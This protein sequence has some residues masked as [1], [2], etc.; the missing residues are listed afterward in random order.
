MD[1]RRWNRSQA[2]YAAE[3]EAQAEVDKDFTH[4]GTKADG[5]SNVWR[6]RGGGRKLMRLKLGKDIALLEPSERG[7]RLPR[8]VRS[9]SDSSGFKIFD[10][11]EK[12]T[13]ALS[14]S[15][16]TGVVGV[17][18]VTNNPVGDLY[19]SV[20]ASAVL[21]DVELEEIRQQQKKQEQEQ[22]VPEKAQQYMQGRRGPHR[23]VAN[24]C[25]R[26]LA[27]VHRATAPSSP[28]SAPTTT[29]SE[30]ATPGFS[31]LP[32]WDPD[33]RPFQMPTTKLSPFA[34]S[35]LPEPV[36][37][38]FGGTS[39][40]SHTSQPSKS[41]ATATTNNVGEDGSSSSTTANNTDPSPPPGAATTTPTK[42][43]A[44]CQW[45]P[46]KRGDRVAVM[47]GT[48]KDF[49]LFPSFQRLLFR[50]LSRE[51]FED[52][53]ARV[54]R[55]PCP[56][57]AIVV[58]NTSG[59]GAVR[60]VQQQMREQG[61]RMQ[62]ELFQRQQSQQEEEQGEGSGRDIAALE[63]GEGSAAN[64]TTTGR[65]RAWMSW[66]SPRRRQDGTR[67][68]SNSTPVNITTRT[69]DTTAIGP[70]LGVRLPLP[71]SSES[72]TAFVDGS[73]SSSS[74][75]SSANS[76]CGRSSGEEEMKRGHVDDEKYGR[77]VEETDRIP[78]NNNQRVDI[79]D[80]KAV[81]AAALDS[82]ITTTNNNLLSSTK[83]AQGTRTN[84]ESPEEKAQRWQI[85]EE[86]F[87][88]EDY[89]S[90]EYSYA[91]SSDE[92]EDEL[93]LDYD[94]P[95]Y[96]SEE[97]GSSDDD[98]G[99]SD[100]DNGARGRR[101]GGNEAATER[102]RWG[103]LDWIHFI[104]FCTPHPRTL[105]TSDSLGTGRS[106]STGTGGGGV[107]ESRR[108]RR[109]RLRR[110]RW[111]RI[112]QR[113][114]EQE[115]ESL[116]RYLP[117]TIRRRMTAQDVHR[118]CMVAEFCRFYLTILMALFLMGAIVYGAVHAESSPPPS[119]KPSQAQ[120]QGQVKDVVT[121]GGGGGGSLR[122]VPAGQWTSNAEVQALGASGGGEAKGDG[123]GQPQ[124]Q[125]QPLGTIAVQ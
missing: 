74:S 78:S 19:R 111:Q 84:K 25:R 52:R 13:N 95:Y 82:A 57:T 47:I 105:A 39:I 106:A 99:G 24:K 34:I 92:E 36:A 17:T 103:I 110:E 28:L 89:D 100:D 27:R 97:S 79:I 112:Q 113:Q 116:H 12:K 73:N 101:G 29:P 109:R 37:K 68:D 90:S 59:E 50:H 48:S 1:W 46:V 5:Q 30:G 32:W 98:G 60:S 40:Y 88:R 62:Q 91:S 6:R 87:L 14:V 72:T 117:A 33:P 77:Q 63:E 67:A 61:D 43:T 104:T 2:T 71:P 66:M 53:V 4:L 80:E 18:S 26:R 8:R 7:L 20:Q 23:R 70:E 69:V 58:T 16:K 115:S 22:E 9:P 10:R 11:G 51:D 3:A 49:L 15:T 56:A 125:Q 108:A 85:L 102:R 86:R 76:S 45:V 54:H 120:W 41:N 93:P 94:G 96:S 118:C 107:F 114:R 81:T 75:S 38:L 65:G 124:Q 21:N 119:P 123:G 122:R 83:T 44:G 35:T 31:F 121:M 64:T 42:N 55:I